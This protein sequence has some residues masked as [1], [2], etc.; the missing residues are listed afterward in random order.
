MY[1]EIRDPVHGPIGL[2]AGELAV[3]DTVTY[4]RLRNI[5]QL[6][7]AEM[8]FPGATHNRYVHGLGAM[9]IAGKA[10][11]AV[12][13]DATWMSSG[14]RDRLRQT[15]RLAALLHDIG[16]PP[17]SHAAERMLPKLSA[18][19]EVWKSETRQATHE[20]MTLALLLWGELSDVIDRQW[21][22]LGIRSVH[23][24]ALIHADF[25]M[26]SPEPFVVQ[27]RNLR[28]VL[29]QLVSSE[30][31]VDR[32][33]Y[34]LRDSYYTGVSY[35]RY[36]L[37]WLVGGLTIHTDETNDVYLALHSRALLTFEDFL[38]SRLHMF[39]MVY[40]H[41]RTNAYDRML[42]RFFETLG[43][44]VT[45]PGG[46]Q[47]YV[48]TDDTSLMELLRHHRSNNWADRILR[49]AP[50]PRVVDLSGPHE[51]A[52]QSV[53]DY[54]LRRIGVEPEWITSH[55]ILSKYQ[56]RDTASLPLFVIA[57]RANG[58]TEAVLLKDATD[59]FRRYRDS[60]VLVRLHTAE[61][62]RDIARSVVSRVLA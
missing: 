21:N 60:T 7:F 46:I 40:F 59:L 50:L 20:D 17:L 1:R 34:L 9:F 27:G 45:L 11:D 39:L 31:D 36:D 47:H 52:A 16:H 23:V 22:V 30:L 61:T 28:P 33:D 57:E 8:T 25:P 53:I 62:D 4:Q 10:F 43:T 56:C 51:Q 42:E 12:F 24:A 15:V 26:D 48:E 32:M 35:G 6:G 44:D 3:V 14:V 5:R 38:L 54:E 13:R 2:C 37:D 19:N 29:S 58:K 55:G 49:H 18:V 41:H